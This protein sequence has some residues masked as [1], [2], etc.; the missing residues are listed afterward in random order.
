ML[1]RHCW[2]QRKPSPCPVFTRKH[3][4]CRLHGSRCNFLSLQQGGLEG[5]YQHGRDRESKG[6]QAADLLGRA[7]SRTLVLKKKQCKSS[8]LQAPL[9]EWLGT[10][11]RLIRKKLISG[12]WWPQSDYRPE[13]WGYLCSWFELFHRSS[14]S[15]G[16][17]GGEQYITGCYL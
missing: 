8:S 15:L 12:C 17:G 10:D 2:I 1:F 14:S 9:Y 7:L 16:M 5:Q 4:H 6:L 11:A 13:A 3:H